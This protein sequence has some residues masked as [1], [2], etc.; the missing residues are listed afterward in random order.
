MFGTFRI[1]HNWLRRRA[2][3]KRQMYPLVKID[4]GHFLITST[5]MTLNLKLLLSSFFSFIFFLTCPLEGV[6]YLQDKLFYSIQCRL[7]TTQTTTFFFICTSLSGQMQYRT[8]V[9]QKLK[10]TILWD[11][12]CS[13]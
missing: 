5:N 12:H 6:L 11:R 1:F 8:L 2:V 9:F 13:F 7:N 10:V 3:E 4:K